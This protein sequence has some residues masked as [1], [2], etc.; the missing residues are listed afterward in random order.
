MCFA[1]V[2]VSGLSIRNVIRGKQITSE[3]KE[4]SVELESEGR[5]EKL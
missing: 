5:M 2:T 4:H 1:M 3:I